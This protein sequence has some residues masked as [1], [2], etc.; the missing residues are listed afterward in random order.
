[1]TADISDAFDVAMD[2]IERGI[3]PTPSELIA[4]N[5]CRECTGFGYHHV[6]DDEGI[7]EVTCKS[8]GGSGR[9]EDNN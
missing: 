5:L 2:K 6:E 4:A 3:T 9:H 7:Y 8:C 1:M